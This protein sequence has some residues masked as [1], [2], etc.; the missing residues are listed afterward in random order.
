MTTRRYA[1]PVDAQL[2]LLTK[3][4]RMYHERGILQAEIASHLNISQAKVSRLLKRAAAV[5]IVRTTVTIAPGLHTALEE[6]LEQ[7]FGI[8]EAVVVDVDPEADDREIFSAIGAAAAT[9]LETTMSGDEKVGIASW[10]Q[11]L[12]ATVDRMRPLPSR[13]ATDVVQLLGG[14]G[15]PE[16]QSQAHRLVD[17]FAR[18]LGA[19]PV[20]VQAPGIV[21]DKQMQRRLMRDPALAD[22]GRR[23]KELTTAVV[24]IGSIQPSDLLAVSG[25]A[26]SADE[27]ESLVAAGAV[28]DICH[29]VF[30]LDG[31]LIT[32]D[33]DDRTVSIPVDDFRA[34]PRRI[35][36]AGGSRKLAPILGALN[37]RWVTTLV[38]DVVTA[39]ALLADERADD[40]S[41]SEEVA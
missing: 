11:T 24:G 8:A 29:R 40:A 7:R 21:Q 19:N 32:G 4:A 22:V 39:E 18:I 16:V 2:R 15:V 12:L 30:R 31:S 41:A 1:P 10:S 26:F 6:E 33:I 17:Q 38:T 5:G 23:W 28:G 3:V 25:N 20:Y 27:T 9:Y 36:V 34:I 37:G 13:G 14:I 35:G